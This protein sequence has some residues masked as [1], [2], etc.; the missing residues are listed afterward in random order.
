MDRRGAVGHR[1]H[2]LAQGLRP[3]VAHRVD[4]GETGLG[5]LIRHNIAAP[6]QL[7]LAL[8]QLGG[9]FP[10]HADEHAVTGKHRLLAGAYIPQLHAGELVAV[11]QFGDHAVPAELQVFRLY[12]RTVVDL[13]GP[14]GIPAVDQDHL[15]GDAAQDQGVGGG[16]VAAPHHD[17]RFAFVPHAVAGG[18]VGHAPAG[19]GGLIGKAQRSGIGPPWP[20]PRF[21]R[22]MS[23][24]WSP[25]LWGTGRGPC[26]P[27][28][29]T[30]SVR[31]SAPPAAASSH[32]G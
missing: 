4:P 29:R 5:R 2:H 1:R 24:R 31:R 9:G 15:L 16:G 22:E 3:H 8:H 30:L 13:G 18:A 26:V 27:P 23:P 10:P 6:V 32:P 12:Q 20:A 14:Q 25:E 19:E 17:H 11:E 28:G 7:Q 21:W